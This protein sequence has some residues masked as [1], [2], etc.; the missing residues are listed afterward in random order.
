[1]CEQSIAA[2]Q[3]LNWVQSCHYLGI[4]VESISH[5]N[6]D[7][8]EAKKSCYH[9]FNA[10]V[11]RVDRLANKHFT[12]ELLNKKCLPTLLYAFEVCRAH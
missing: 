9:S 1:M 6:C 8:S 4:T 7:V 3:E 10:F 2:G 11:G 5:F 12:V